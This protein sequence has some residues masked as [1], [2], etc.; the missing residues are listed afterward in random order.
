VKK[1]D[2]EFGFDKGLNGS[3]PNGT[4]FISIWAMN[5]PMPEF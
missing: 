5:A 2:S 3:V 4:P 1:D